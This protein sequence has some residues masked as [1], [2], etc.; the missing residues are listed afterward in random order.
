MT[1]DLLLDL[2][3]DELRDINQRLYEFRDKVTV[4]PNTV[5]CGPTSKLYMIKG[6]VLGLTIVHDSSQPVKHRIAYVL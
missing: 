5:I 3:M 2:I 6:I 4:E 1:V